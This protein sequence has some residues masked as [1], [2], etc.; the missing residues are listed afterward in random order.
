MC[1][2]GTDNH[3]DINRCTDGH[4][5]QYVD[6]RGG[7]NAGAH[8]D[9]N[10]NTSTPSC[11]HSNVDSHTSP[12]TDAYT[13]SGGDSNTDADPNSH[14]CSNANLNSN[15]Y[16]I[17]NRRTASY[18]NAFADPHTNAGAAYPHADADTSAHS[19]AF[20]ADGG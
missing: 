16:T 15:S 9:P 3:G 5:D 14:T 6:A 11:P 13:H 2:V 8:G 1:R 12:D 18:P 19:S 20:A 4:P 10:T 7:G 17:S